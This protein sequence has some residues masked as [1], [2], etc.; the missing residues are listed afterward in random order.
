VT[1]LRATFRKVLFFLSTVVFL[2]VLYLFPR[3]LWA[4][5]KDRTVHSRPSESNKGPRAQFSEKCPSTDD[6]YKTYGP[7]NPLSGQPSSFLTATGRYFAPLSDAS[8]DQSQ[9][10]NLKGTKKRSILRI[11]TWGPTETKYSLPTTSRN[12]GQ[13]PGSGHSYVQ[14]YPKGWVYKAAHDSDFRRGLSEAFLCSLG[15]VG[16]RENIELL[17][18]WLESNDKK[19]NDYT[20]FGSDELKKFGLECSGDAQKQAQERA[21]NKVMLK[22]VSDLKTLQETH[23]NNPEILD[24]LFAI[25]NQTK[26]NEENLEAGKKELVLTPEFKEQIDKVISLKGKD[27]AELKD[28]E[29]GLLSFYEDFTAGS[30][31]NTFQYLVNPVLGNL[32]TDSV[33]LKASPSNSADIKHLE[34]ARQNIAEALGLQS[35]NL[36]YDSSNLAGKITP[37]PMDNITPVITWAYQQFLKGNKGSDDE[38]KIQEWVQKVKNYEVDLWQAVEQIRQSEEARKVAE[39]PDSPSNTQGVDFAYE[40]FLG[41]KVQGDEARLWKD[42]AI[43]GGERELIKVAKEIFNSP[44]ASRYRCDE[45]IQVQ[46][47][48]PSDN[49]AERVSRRMAELRTQERDNPLEGKSGTPFRDA[50][51]KLQEILQTHSEHGLWN[52]P[53]GGRLKRAVSDALRTDDSKDPGR[54]D[55]FAKPNPELKKSIPAIEAFSKKLGLPYNAEVALKISKLDPI[56]RDLLNHLAKDNSFSVSDSQ[57]E[58]LSMFSDQGRLDK[59]VEALFDE[60]NPSLFK[61]VAGFVTQKAPELKDLF[62]EMGSY[63]YMSKEANAAYEKFRH[64]F[65][66]RVSKANFKDLSEADRAKL[67]GIM[68][69]DEWGLKG[70]T[71]RD[72]QERDESDYDLHYY[73]S[74]LKKEKEILSKICEGKKNCS[75]IE[76]EQ[77]VLKQAHQYLG[78]LTGISPKLRQVILERKLSDPY[79]RTMAAVEAKYLAGEELTNGEKEKWTEAQAKLESHLGPDKSLNLSRQPQQFLDRIGLFYPLGDSRRQEAFFAPITRKHL[80][81]QNEFQAFAIGSRFLPKPQEDRPSAEELDAFASLNPEGQKRL[82]QALSLKQQQREINYRLA[83]QM[84]P[85]VFSKPKYEWASELNAVSEALMLI[86]EDTDSDLAIRLTA[87]STYQKG[88]VEREK[89]FE[90]IM[91][92][93]KR[94]FT[95]SG[96]PEQAELPLSQAALDHLFDETPPS[97]STF[98]QALKEFD[99]TQKRLDSIVEEMSKDKT[100]RPEVVER[101]LALKDNLVRA[102]RQ[103]Q[104]PISLSADP[105][106][107]QASFDSAATQHVR[108]GLG[109]DQLKPEVSRNITPAMKSPPVASSDLKNAIERLKGMGLVYDPVTNELVI[110]P[111]AKLTS[112]EEL[113]SVLKKLP[114]IAV[115]IQVEDGIEIVL[116]PKEPQ[117]AFEDALLRRALAFRVS[118]KKSRFSFEVDEIGKFNNLPSNEKAQH[119]WF[120]VSDQTAARI[121]YKDAGDGKL[122]L[123]YEF[124]PIQQI[125]DELKGRLVAIQQ[126]RTA[127]LK[128]QK[129]MK[130]F[131]RAW[132]NLGDAMLSNMLHLYDPELAALV[133]TNQSLDKVEA[134][135]IDDVLRH[136]DNFING[137]GSIPI[138]GTD[139]KAQDYS[140]DVLSRIRSEK[141]KT[142]NAAMEIQTRNIDNISDA[143]IAAA[144]IPVLGPLGRGLSAGA[145]WA[146]LGDLAVKGTLQQRIAAKS[147]MALIRSVQAIPASVQHG[148][149]VAAVFQGIGSGAKVAGELINVYFGER[150]IQSRIEWAK[151]N[152][153]N[154]TGWRKH[155]V[156][157]DELERFKGKDKNEEEYK[158]AVLEWNI[159]Q[160]LDLNGDGYIDMLVES[161]KDLGYTNNLMTRLTD[162]VFNMDEFNGYLG[163]AQFFANLHWAGH[164]TGAIGKRLI[165]G[166]PWSEMPVASVLGNLQNYY[167]RPY[168]WKERVEALRQKAEMEGKPLGAVSPAAEVASILLEDAKENLV[169]GLTFSAAIGAN[170]GLMGAAGLSQPG[171]RNQLAGTLSFMGTDFAAKE[172]VHW[173]RHWKSG[174]S[175]MTPEQVGEHLLEHLS[176]AAYIGWGSS[177]GYLERSKMEGQQKSLLTKGIQQYREE[178]RKEFEEK[179]RALKKK[180]PQERL[181]EQEQ[182]EVSESVDYHVEGLLRSLEHQYSSADPKTIEDIAKWRVGRLETSTKA[183]RELEGSVRGNQEL[184]TALKTI[185]EG[186]KRLNQLIIEGQWNRVQ[187]IERITTD[188]VAANRKMQEHV[189]TQRKAVSEVERVVEKKLTRGELLTESEKATQERALELTLFSQR[190]LRA[191]RSA[192]ELREF[193]VPIEQAA[194]VLSGN[195][196]EFPEA[197]KALESQ[198]KTTK[199]TAAVLSWL[200]NN[201]IADLTP[202]RYGRPGYAAGFLESPGVSQFP[203]VHR[204]AVDTVLGAYAKRATT[205][206]QKQQ[207][208][209]TLERLAPS[210]AVKLAAKEYK[211][212]SG[213][214]KALAEAVLQKHAPE[215]IPVIE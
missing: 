36:V 172:A 175:G 48:N 3:N 131:W 44:E 158:K 190:L 98:P 46:L 107:A 52:T 177:R 60:K 7:S 207:L 136:I 188:I 189:E 186:Q 57:K 201:G 37:V 163:S 162:R 209:Q 121:L 164:G 78:K 212:S 124:K 14:H 69:L 205:S 197:Q 31:Q 108:I 92:E 129:D 184:E 2:S 115:R 5:E 35:E 43:K 109:Q 145:Q 27:G 62:D 199:L 171:I 116:P 110:Q 174:L 10:P 50:A 187:E 13:S 191:T 133:D 167:F 210:E 53:E 54:V 84:K 179:Y 170:N 120:P 169:S 156:H 203:A 140:H 12:Y 64:D 198:R 155:K 146:K 25:F 18:T 51:N 112:K 101:V 63:K 24:F 66:D 204:A 61:S 123:S 166:K 148:A 102:Y 150:Y 193:S 127:Y 86:G 93:M 45:K 38:S 154:P 23:A 132:R 15:K 65:R 176:T 34:T 94:L 47:K 215:Q 41:R 195:V 142:D 134:R 135:R 149:K 58:S 180:K 114:A 39:E 118:P 213:D 178:A 100:I 137:A 82:N 208:L 214:L 70:V 80:A 83:T 56:Y 113:L 122:E 11:A 125:Q 126:L 30:Y 138:P 130:S 74:E 89:L 72:K 17:K 29:R 21:K 85:W 67:L 59:F 33:R 103:Q 159:E 4:D 40:I 144:S 96:Y 194:S 6:F 88:S 79:L 20:N 81:R 76:V 1:N 95:E 153:D 106:K 196:E 32:I 141:M 87:Y 183:V 90:M 181:S 26:I 157:P 139:M 173:G 165:G 206:I 192:A 75:E 22:V 151:N 182:K 168:A 97:F 9:I 55:L 147:A 42:R 8:F 161:T 143:I 117:K 73:F 211:T 19:L 68:L 152:P 77:E 16:K 160:E 185:E 200:K 105:K 49:M 71:S 104:M 128:N 111:N 28:S 99:T 202:D 91:A 119:K